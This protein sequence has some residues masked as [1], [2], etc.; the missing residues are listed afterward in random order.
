MPTELLPDGLARET[1][2]HTVRLLRPLPLPNWGTARLVQHT[3][4]EP[5]LN[6]LST[7]S[8]CRIG[9]LLDWYRQWDS[10]PL[11]RGEGPV[12]QPNGSG[13]MMVPPT[14]LEPV[15]SGVRNRCLVRLG[16]GGIGRSP[17]T[18]T[19][20]DR[21]LRAVPLPIGLESEWC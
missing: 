20:T 5:V 19:R 21:L 4:L 2:T 17:E 16:Q 13:G 3:G 12:P 11:I 9:V 1:R 18:R 6:G 10:N 15:I 7:R 14:G 8:L